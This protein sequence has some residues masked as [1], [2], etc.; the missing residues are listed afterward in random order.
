M[1]RGAL[2]AAALLA[3]LLGGCGSDGGMV[4]P[5]DGE[6]QSALPM[7]TNGLL[8]DRIDANEDPIDWKFFQFDVTDNFFLLVFFD[9]PDVKAEVALYTGAGNRVAST[10]HDSQNEFD[11]LQ[12]PDLREGRYYVRIEVSQGVSVYTI[13]SAPGSMP[14]LG[15]GGGN[16]EPRPE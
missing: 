3:V 16:T 15:D 12:V 7:E 2:A 9:N 6:I 14:M 1:S 5:P 4:G 13:R 10:V 11:L 8:D